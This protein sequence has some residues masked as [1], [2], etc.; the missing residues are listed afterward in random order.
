MKINLFQA[1]RKS[2]G[3]FARA[4]HTVQ[5]LLRDTVEQS[6]RDFGRWVKGAAT[7]YGIGAVLSL[8]AL[9]ALTSSIAWGIA[10]LGLALFASWLIVAAVTGVTAYVLFKTGG[11]KG[12]DRESGRD[13]ERTGLTFRIVQAAPRRKVRS[14]RR[15]YDVHP[16]GEGWEVT[17]G[18]KKRRYTTKNRAVRAAKRSARTGSGRVVIHRSDG[19][20]EEN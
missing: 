11:K 19:R 6:V 2:S 16:G 20:V 5:Q 1:R 10:A 9:F 17:G 8:M 3:F 7:M 4:G 14:T 18:S 13:E 15:V 12:L